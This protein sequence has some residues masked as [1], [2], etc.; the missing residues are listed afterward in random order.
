MGKNG[1]KFKFL[2][3]LKMSGRLVG[4]RCSDDWLNKV[5]QFDCNF[6]ILKLIYNTNEMYIIYSK[7]IKEASEVC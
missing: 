6:K 4:N 3:M 2:L 5:V 1:L 7:S